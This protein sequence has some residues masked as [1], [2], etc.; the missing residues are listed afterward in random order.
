MRPGR[1]GNI[2]PADITFC[3]VDPFLVEFVDCLPYLS[4]Y[5]H[6][7]MTDHAIQQKEGREVAYD[8]DAHQKE[9]YSLEVARERLDLANRIRV[10]WSALRIG[11]HDKQMGTGAL[12]Y[13]LSASDRGAL[14]LLAV[15]LSTRVAIWMTGIGACLALSCVGEVPQPYWERA[16]VTTVVDG[17]TIELDD[18]RKVRYIGINAPETGDFGGDSATEMNRRLVEGKIVHLSYGHDRVDRYGR[19]LAVVRVGDRMVNRELVRAGWAWCY[20]FDGNLRSAV[21]LLRAQREAMNANWGIWRAPRIET[22]DYYVGSFSAFRF[23]RPDCESIVDI[24]RHNEVIFPVKDSA[25]Y[26]GYAPCGRCR[27]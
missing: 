14:M 10:R 11:G 20:F 24:K 4:H 13:S 1:A 22:A 8:N 17:D 19:T 25:F 5:F 9:E 15:R 21:N 3:V 7:F 26:A 12:R 16:R 18:G 27:P 6:F 2:Q 23:H